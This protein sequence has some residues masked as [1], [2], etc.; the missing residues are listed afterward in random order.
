[1]FCYSCAATRLGLTKT[2][3]ISSCIT[4]NFTSSTED[5]LHRDTTAEFR[6]TG[7]ISLHSVLNAL[8]GE[9]VNSLPSHRQRINFGFV[10]LFLVFE[11]AIFAN[12]DVYINCLL[13]VNLKPSFQ[14][15]A[16]AQEYR[17][18]TFVS[19]PG[20]FPVAVLYKF[21]V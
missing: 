16:L 17:R 11:A 3:K 9:F 5:S 7:N 1:M 10:F 21:C 2:S 13:N 18:S 14:T 4:T 6:L 19:A 12:K 8:V 15:I 20:R